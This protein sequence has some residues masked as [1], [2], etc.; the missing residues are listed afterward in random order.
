MI[1]AF[2]PLHL[3]HSDEITFFFKF[4][5]SKLE[6]EN[7]VIKQQTLSCKSHLESVNILSS[8]YKTQI[9][10]KNAIISRLKLENKAANDENLQIK[11]KLNKQKSRIDQLVLEE[12]ATKNQLRT[13]KSELKT[14][15]L[16]L[17]QLESDHESLANQS[18]FCNS[19][20]ND[21][22]SHIKKLESENETN[23]AQLNTY[24]AAKEAAESRAS[25]CYEQLSIKRSEII[26]LNSD[27]RNKKASLT[28]IETRYN[29][30]INSELLFCDKKSLNNIKLLH[31]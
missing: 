23:A 18:A 5:L 28:S 17:K 20:L 19:T 8:T 16:V 29:L 12:E 14:K 1:F 3:V 9:D 31:Q 25:R 13:C 21:Q 7:E 27:L 4:K 6:S 30:V 11:E 2:G 15:L 26:R 10:D 24:K 22:H